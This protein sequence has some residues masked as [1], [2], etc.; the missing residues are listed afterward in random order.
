MSDHVVRAGDSEK[1]DSFTLHILYDT[2]AESPD[3]WGD[4]E[5]FLGRVETAGYACGRE[6]FA[7]VGDY[8]ESHPVEVMK[9]G[10][11]IWIWSNGEQVPYLLFPVMCL[12]GQGGFEL[13]SIQ[14]PSRAHGFI[15]VRVRSDLEQLA[16]TEEGCTAD[17]RA[18]WTLDLWNQWLRG[19][20][21]GYE[22]RDAKGEVAES[23][24]GFYG[25]EDCVGAGRA[26]AAQFELNQEG[27]V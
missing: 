4:Q 1:F 18:A 22:V 21:Y 9:E 5:S 7:I 3:E 14:E 11:D 23:C 26:A 27:G 25:V 8:F 6:G 24:W 16:D 2:E 17:K 12:R 19:D 13:Y 10:G 20:V 15:F